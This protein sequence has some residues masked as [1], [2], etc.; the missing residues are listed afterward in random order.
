ML[1]MC[2]VELVEASHIWGLEKAS[3]GRGLFSRAFRCTASEKEQRKHEE[4]S[5]R[6]HKTG[7][8]P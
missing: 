4:W 1:P 8:D 2:A 5:H 3:L 6:P 7:K